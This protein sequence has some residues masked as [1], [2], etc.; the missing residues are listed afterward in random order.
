MLG[1]FDSSYGEYPSVFILC[2]LHNVYIDSVAVKNAGFGEGSGH[3]WLDDVMCTG[4]ETNIFHCSR[5]V[6]VNA[7]N[8]DHSEDAGVIC[9]GETY[10]VDHTHA[11]NMYV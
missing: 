4:N 3:I 5:G 2:V 10:L 8:C 9:Q 7:S 1:G 6:E 11:Y